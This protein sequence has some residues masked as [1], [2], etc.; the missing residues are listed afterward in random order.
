M[1]NRVSFPVEEH[2]GAV[3]SPVFFKHLHSLAKRQEEYMLIKI[4]DDPN[5]EALHKS[6]TDRE[7]RNLKQEMPK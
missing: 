7:I 3:L 5:W 6:V 1:L 2:Q 4:T